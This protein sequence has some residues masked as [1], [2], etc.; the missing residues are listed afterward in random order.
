MKKL[1]LIFLLLSIP[2]LCPADEITGFI[3]ICLVSGSGVSVEISGGAYQSDN[4][5]LNDTIVHA[6]RYNQE[7]TVSY[8]VQGSQNLIDAVY[9]NR[10]GDYSRMVSLFIGAVSAGAFA[11]GLGVKL[12]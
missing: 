8:T 4:V 10:P 3:D 12:S 9:L 6:F 5:F 11:L 2:A 1:V 7:V